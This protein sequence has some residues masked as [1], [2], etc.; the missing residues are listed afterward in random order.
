MNIVSKIY[1][2]H[3]RHRITGL[4]YFGKTTSDP[5]LY[6]GSG[7]YWSEHLKKYGVLIDTIQAWEFNNTEECSKFAI[8]F[9]I[10]NDIVDK[11][12]GLGKKIWANLK[13]ENG[14]D[15]G[16][17]NLRWYHKEGKSILCQNPPS[18]DW[19][20]G[21][22]NKTSGS[23]GFKWYNNGIENLFTNQKPESPEWVTGMIREKKRTYN[24]RQCTRCSFIGSGSGMTRY[25]FDNCKGE[26]KQAVPG[27]QGKY[28]R[29][30]A[31]CVG[32]R[33][34]LSISNITRYHNTC[35]IQNES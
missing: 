5:Y 2:Y 11:R 30:R 32:C 16:F 33:K 26:R 31:S 17:D 23:S 19:K 8:N 1:L 20:L 22:I 6:H 18:E 4:N 14:I 25:H 10:E 27:N 15:G 21:R 24:N 28:T 7:L 35:G 9:S 13:I 29:L 3:K 34:E 12:D